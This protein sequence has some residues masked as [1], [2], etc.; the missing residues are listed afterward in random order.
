MKLPYV[1]LP[2]SRSTFAFKTRLYFDANIV[3]SRAKRMLLLQPCYNPRS[4]LFFYLPVSALINFLSGNLKRAAQNSTEVS[5]L[6]MLA[7]NTNFLHYSQKVPMKVIATMKKS[8]YKSQFNWNRGS[9]YLSYNMSQKNFGMKVIGSK[10]WWHHE[11]NS[12][13]PRFR[14]ENGPLVFRVLALFI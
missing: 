9:H 3:I 11:T 5:S 14:V 7:L 1:E 10:K 6:K 13:F 2:N 12:I 4:I 8:L